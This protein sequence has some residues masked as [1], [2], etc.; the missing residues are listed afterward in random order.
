[1][2]TYTLTIVTFFVAPEAVFDANLTCW[3]SSLSTEINAF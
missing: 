1:M 3:L 2:T